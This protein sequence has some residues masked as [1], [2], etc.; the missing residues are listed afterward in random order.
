[1]T[2]VKGT[3]DGGQGAA[4]GAGSEKRTTH[5]LATRYTGELGKQHLLMEQ[6]RRRCEVARTDAR[7]RC[8]EGVANESFTCVSYFGE[9][10]VP[11]CLFLKV[12]RRASNQVRQSR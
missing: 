5:K 2:E 9:P 10:K 1:M 6:R 7:R 4:W 11:F 3:V 8:N 12:F